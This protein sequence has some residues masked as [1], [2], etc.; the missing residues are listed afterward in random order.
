MKEKKMKITSTG[1]SRRQ[2]R[3]GGSEHAGRGEGARRGKE[4]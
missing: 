4:R 3:D 2:R 1:V